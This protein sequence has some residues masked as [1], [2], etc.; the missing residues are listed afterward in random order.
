[1]KQ[2]FQILLVILLAGCELLDS[3][4][5]I[6]QK[7]SDVL[8][9]GSRKEPVLPSIP[10]QPSGDTLIYLA[11]VEFP[12]DYDWLRDTANGSVSFNL[13]LFVNGKK[14]ISVPSGEEAYLSPDPDMHFLL[15]GHLYTVFAVSGHTIVKCDGAELFRY[16]G[17]EVI[18]GFI[19]KEDGIYTLGQKKKGEGF[20]YRKNGVELFSSASGYVL[21]DMCEQGREHGALFHNGEAVCFIYY[22]PVVGAS[23]GYRSWFIVEDGVKREVKPVR[24]LAEIFDVGMIDGKICMVGSIGKDGVLPVLIV[25][26]K[27]VALLTAG[28]EVMKNGRLIFS[29]KKIFVKG[30]LEALYP[31]FHTTAL[32]NSQGDRETLSEPGA[33]AV[34]FYFEDSDYAYTIAEGPYFLSGICHKGNKSPLPERVVMAS[35]RCGLV[36]GGKFY[37][38]LT[39]LQYGKSPFLWAEGKETPLD[40]NGYLTAIHVVIKE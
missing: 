30:V 9:D 23:S 31:S 20:S 38:A 27:I 4:N 26:Q 22:L 3:G 39:P 25:G 17:E 40:F 16:E 5:F 32:W 34:D 6:G 11:G 19:L 8:R 14:T 36:K 29:D 33:K 12:K 10:E 13:V 35:N 2:L 37:A 15:S 21:G 28:S 7:R 24:T 18:K 1:M